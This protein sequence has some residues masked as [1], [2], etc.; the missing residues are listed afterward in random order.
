MPVKIN[1]GNDVVESLLEVV[2]SLFIDL[3]CNKKDF[4]GIGLF[5]KVPPGFREHQAYFE[6]YVLINTLSQLWN[7]LKLSQGLLLETKVLTNLSRYSSHMAEAVFEGW[8]IDGAQPVLEFTGQILEYLQQPEVAEAKSVRL[9]NQFT[10]NIRLVFLRVT[11]WRL[12]ELDGTID[13]AGTVAFLD[14]MN[15]WQTILF[16]AENQETLFIRLICFMLYLK[17]VSEVQTV[18]LAAARIWRTI[19]VQK[20][21]ESATLLTYAM[22][23][24]QRHCLQDS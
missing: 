1:V 9:C 23:S 7:H 19:L 20:P 13:E 6:S 3:V 22:G 16:S 4:Q 17:L 11:L 21:T 5:L 12:A 18:R 24:E 14:K 2:V 8:F 15:Y 10:S